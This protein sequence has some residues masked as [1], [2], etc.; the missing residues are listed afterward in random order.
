M[1]CSEHQSRVHEMENQKNG[2]KYGVTKSNQTDKPISSR[3]TSNIG[4][5]PVNQLE[6]VL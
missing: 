1:F 5:A 2:M 3:F 6:H 4:W